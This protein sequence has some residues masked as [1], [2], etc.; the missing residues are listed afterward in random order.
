VNAPALKS[1]M[2]PAA[3]ANRYKGV[4]VQTATPAQIVALLYGGIL[5]FVGEADAAIEKTDRA[6]AG[7][8][9][10]KAMAIVDELA[11][12]LDPSH[13]PELAENLAALY[14]FC[15]RRLFDANLNQ[16]RKALADVVIAVTPLKEAWSTIAG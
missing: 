12:T 3:V 2:S 1:V 11:A 5:R 10:G 16:D 15:K 6:R 9:I 7:E 4:Q 13:A 8:R 14:G